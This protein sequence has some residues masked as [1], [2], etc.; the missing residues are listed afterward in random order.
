MTEHKLLSGENL[1]AAIQE[2]GPDWAVLPGKGLV[3][4]ISTNGFT[5]GI[6]LIDS[7]ATIAERKNH[8]PELAIRSDEVEIILNTHAAGGITRLDIELAQAIDSTLE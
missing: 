3:R 4:V 5:E 7:I 1:K 2:I 8:H 6:V